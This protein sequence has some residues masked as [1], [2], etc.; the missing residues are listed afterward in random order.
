V[1]AVGRSAFL[2]GRPAAR[3]VVIETFLVAGGLLF[4]RFLAGHSALAMVLSVWSFF[5][6]QSFYFLVGE[7]RQ[8]ERSGAHPDP[9]EDARARA[10]ALLD[11]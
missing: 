2:Y 9:F 7:A 6:V 4:A 11:A 3:A 8:R 1:L 10:L 5:L